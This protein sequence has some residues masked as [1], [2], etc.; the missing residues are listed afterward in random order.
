MS[1][2]AVAPSSDEAEQYPSPVRGK[3]GA[4]PTPAGLDNEARELW[5]M[6]FEDALQVTCQQAVDPRKCAIQTAWK[7]VKEKYGEKSEDFVA[8]DGKNILEK[9]VDKFFSP[10]ERGGSGSG[11]FGHAGRPGKVGGS[12]SSGISSPRVSVN[13]EGKQRFT[14]IADTSGRNMKRITS[15][16]DIDPQSKYYRVLNCALNREY[17]ATH[18]GGIYPRQA[19]DASTKE[20]LGGDV[21]LDWNTSEPYRDENNENPANLTFLDRLGLEK[22]LEVY[23]PDVENV[24]DVHTAQR[25]LDGLKDQYSV[26]DTAGNKE[27][28][29]AIKRLMGLY[30]SRKQALKNKSLSEKSMASKEETAM[31]EDK[32]TLAARGAGIDPVA[33]QKR[34]AVRAKEAAEDQALLNAGYSLHPARRPDDVSSVEWS[35]LPLEEKTVGAVVWRQHCIRNYAEAVENA[36]LDGWKAEKNPHRRTEWIFKSWVDTPDGWQLVRGIL[37]RRADKPDWYMREVSRGASL[38]L[39]IRVAPDEVRR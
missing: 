7:T 17:Y 3:D 24:T 31:V 11:N 5:I 30:M 13:A 29:N 33:L 1:D 15:H 22:W 32:L 19:M 14:G 21:L 6:A 38:S 16:E 8:R 37:V 18:V 23:S 25:I 20:M 26:A 39:A 35:A 12:A 9:L 27:H 2:T 28:R 34:R 10:V 36:V 4:I